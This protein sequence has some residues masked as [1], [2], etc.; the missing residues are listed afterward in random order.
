[1]S[2]RGAPLPD[3]AQYRFDGV[4]LLIRERCLRRDGIADL[5]TLNR[6]AGLDA[7]RKVIS[8]EDLVDAP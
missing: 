6:K 5:V 3:I 2:F 7:G 8:R 1:L 4:A